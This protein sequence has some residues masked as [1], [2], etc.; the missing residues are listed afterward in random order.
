MTPAPL[1]DSQAAFLKEAA[2]YL[3]RPGYLMRLADLV[4]VPAQKL[5]E[6]AVPDRVLKISNDALTRAMGL[7]A[8]TVLAGGPEKSFEEAYAR[9]GWSDRLHMLATM[10][11][12]GVGGLFGLGGLT[13]E[14]PLTTGIMFRSIA[15]IADD[16]GEDIQAP[17]V[18]LECLSVFSHGGGCPADDAMESSYLTARVGLAQ[19]IQEAAQFVASRTAKEFSEAVA[20][21]AAP[22]LVRFLSRVAAEFNVVVSQKFLAQSLPVIGMATG[23]LINAAFTDHFN[24]VA[25]YHF[26]IRKLERQYGAERVQELYRAELRR[27][28]QGRR[29]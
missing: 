24:S 11:S 6:R 4:G 28:R 13:V 16:F 17:A 20:K 21:G 27:L 2:R 26:G 15:S 22:A 25:R 29:G 5:V 18:R 12:G 8:G 10:V 7:A 19:L 3:E 1:T 9:S 23:A 14:L